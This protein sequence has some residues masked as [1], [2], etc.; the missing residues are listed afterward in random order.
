MTLT[1]FITHPF[2][3]IQSPLVLFVDGIEHRIEEASVR[4]SE[5]FLVMRVSKVP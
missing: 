4:V 1:T 3:I 2:N 5:V